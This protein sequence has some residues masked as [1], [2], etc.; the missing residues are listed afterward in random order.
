MET[1]VDSEEWTLECATCDEKTTRMRMVKAGRKHI[2]R[3]CA[4]DVVEKVTYQ[5]LW[6]WKVK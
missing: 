5:I 4:S 1:T 3:L 2:C 6:D